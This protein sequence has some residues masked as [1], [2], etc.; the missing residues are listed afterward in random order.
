MARNLYK[1]WLLL[2]VISGAIA[3]WF[4]WSL[5]SELWKFTQLNAQTTAVVSHWKVKDLP[6]SRFAVEAEFL[7]E[8]EGTVHKGKTIFDRPQFLNRFAAEN[9]IKI[10]QA[11]SWQTWYKKSD[12]A[13][14]NL[15]REFPQ[16][17]CLQTLLTVGVFA[18]FY[19]ARSLLSKASS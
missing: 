10:L 16:K 19:F 18:Y 1:M 15:E 6:S 13:F 3:L 4:S 17:Q 5:A 11:K 14:S 7:Y 2:L 12:P 9:E 8:V